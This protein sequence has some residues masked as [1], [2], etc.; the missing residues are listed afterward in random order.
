MKKERKE[1]RDKIRRLSYVKITNN[2]H[3]LAIIF[4][5]SDNQIRNIVCDIV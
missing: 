5:L 1:I 4:D 2:V 3:I